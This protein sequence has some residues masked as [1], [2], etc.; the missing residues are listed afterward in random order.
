MKKPAHRGATA[1]LSNAFR[2]V[3]D[4]RYAPE[5]A[6]R[7]AQHIANRFGLSPLHAALIAELAFPAADNW[8]GR[9]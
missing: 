6:P 1:G 7:Q 2:Q 5:I 4:E 8:R 3:S 9:A